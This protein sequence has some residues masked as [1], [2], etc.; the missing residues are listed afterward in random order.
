[1]RIHIKPRKKK[2]FGIQRYEPEKENLDIVQKM[3]TELNI[4]DKKIV[5]IISG[6]IEAQKVQIKSALTQDNNWLLKFQKKW[7][8]SAAL[9][10]AKW[11]QANLIYLYK[12]RNQLQR[13]LDKAT[14]Q[15]WPKKIK[16]IIFILT[17]ILMAS[18]AF[19]LTVSLSPIVMVLLLAYLV[20]S[21]KNLIP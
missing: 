6:L 8:N 13:T 4:I 16:K 15:Y 5:E 18:L 7:V 20:M 12:E 1:M 21:K 17:L 14:G 9:K 19:A 11:H 10:S 2:E 3:R